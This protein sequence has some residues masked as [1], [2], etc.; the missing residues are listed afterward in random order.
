M[1]SLLLFVVDI[2]TLAFVRGHVF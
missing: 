2:A 1:M